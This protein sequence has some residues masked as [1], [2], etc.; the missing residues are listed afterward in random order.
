MGQNHGSMSQR[1]RA[2][3]LYQMVCTGNVEAIK[4]LCR[5][6]ASLE[7]KLIHLCSFSSTFKF[8]DLH[9]VLDFLMSLGYSRIMGFRIVIMWKH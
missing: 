3:S 1:S 5:E 2:E 8:P 7:V 4:A 9:L 6:G